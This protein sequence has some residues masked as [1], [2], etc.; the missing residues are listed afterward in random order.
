MSTLDLCVCVLGRGALGHTTVILPYKSYLNVND[1]CKLDHQ[2]Q[3]STHN[4]TIYQKKVPKFKSL[5]AGPLSQSNLACLMFWSG[6]CFICSRYF[7]A[8]YIFWQSMFCRGRYLR[9]LR[10]CCSSRLMFQ[11]CQYTIYS[12]LYALK[13]L[14]FCIRIW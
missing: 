6:Q 1:Y 14:L 10:E 11:C 7:G 9:Y 2:F 12:H 4:L 5:L 3:H 8:V 13:I